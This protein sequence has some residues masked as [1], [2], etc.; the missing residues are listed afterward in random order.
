M[1]SKTFALTFATNE[2]QTTHLPLAPLP[3]PFPHLATS[4]DA[5]H[6]AE[7]GGLASCP[8]VALT[9]RERDPSDH[10]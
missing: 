9:E 6:A 4:S 5:W 3:Y 1:T 10:N 2:S 7:D 8:F